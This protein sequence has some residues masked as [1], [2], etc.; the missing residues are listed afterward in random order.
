MSMLL[1]QSFELYAIILH[2]SSSIKDERIK[3]DIL[4]NNVY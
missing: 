3:K 1:I 4:G 2:D